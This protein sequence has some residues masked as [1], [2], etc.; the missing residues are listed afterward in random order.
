[1][2]RRKI[3]IAVVQASLP[4][5]LVA[6]PLAAAEFRPVA[7]RADAECYSNPLGK[8]AADKMTSPFSIGTA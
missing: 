7:V 3:S 6:C 4:L 5:M 8:Y 2:N 1:M